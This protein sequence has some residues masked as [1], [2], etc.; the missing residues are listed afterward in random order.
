MKDARVKLVHYLERFARSESIDIEIAS[1]ASAE[2]LLEDI[3][4][5]HGDYDL[6][7]LDIYMEGMDGIQAA[8]RLREQGYPGQIVFSTSSVE[9]AIDGY[10]VQAAG[11]LIKPFSYERFSTV[12]RLVCSR[13][14]DTLK[15]ITVT[16][17]RIQR[18][19]AYRDILYIETE[20]RNSVIRTADERIRCRVTLADFEK[21]LDREPCF[22]RSH[23]SYIVN[24]NHIAGVYPDYLLMD[25]GERV[26][27]NIRNSLKIRQHIADYGFSLMED[28]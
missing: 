15:S 3:R 16:S 10:D 12:M 21:T 25:N 18:R 24:M 1:F 7:F 23:R 11:Y 26:L 27:I 20:N 14:D 6:I 8:G 13:V 2:K 5:R 19:I 17:E 9:H 28:L 4:D 22:L